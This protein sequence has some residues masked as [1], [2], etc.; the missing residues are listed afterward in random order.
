MGNMS[1]PDV[2]EHLCSCK[3]GTQFSAN[4]SG[5]LFAGDSFKYEPAA[6]DLGFLAAS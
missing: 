4:I 3:E 6:F 5:V 2:T 1:T